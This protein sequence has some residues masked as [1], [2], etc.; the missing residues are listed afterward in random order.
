MTTVEMK[1]QVLECAKKLYEDY[2]YADL[3]GA[4]PGHILDLAA[5]IVD[6]IDNDYP[7]FSLNHAY[8]WILDVDNS[9]A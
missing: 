5:E 4:Y 9:M 1:K 6:L 3:I 8:N 7:H 2:T